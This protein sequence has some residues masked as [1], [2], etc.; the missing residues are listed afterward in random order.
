[1][2][3]VIGDGLSDLGSSD[4]E[5]DGEDEE[6]DEDDTDLRKLRDDDEPGWVMGTISKTV[7]HR[8]ESFRKKQMKLDKLTQPCWGMQ[9]TTLVRGI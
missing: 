5:Q 6:Y 7:Q 8:L 1:M 4:E 9:P 3:N 2:F